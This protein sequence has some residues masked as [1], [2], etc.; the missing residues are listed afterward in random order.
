MNTDIQQRMEMIS[1]ANKILKSNNNNN[2]NNNNN[3]IDHII[4]YSLMICNKYNVDHA[5]VNGA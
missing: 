3:L 2:N 1:D 4:S 5:E